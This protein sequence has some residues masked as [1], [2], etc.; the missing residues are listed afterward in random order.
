MTQ[1]QPQKRLLKERVVKIWNLF[2]L[3][4]NDIQEKIKEF[5]K[6]PID[7]IKSILGEFKKEI[8]F[9]ILSLIVIFVLHKPFFKFI[10]KTLVHNIFGYF[11]SNLFYFNTASRIVLCGVLVVLVIFGLIFC[12]K[13][14]KIA[15]R[16]AN[17]DIFWIVYFTI[18]WSILRFYCPHLEDIP[19]RLS[20][21]TRGGTLCYIDLWCLVPFGGFII[22][23]GSYRSRILLRK[24]SSVLEEKKD[25]TPEGKKGT[26]LEEKDTTS[27]EINKSLLDDKELD[28]YNELLPSRQ[29]FVDFIL[30]EIDGLG[31][32][33][34]FSFGITSPWGGGKT[35]FLNG[36]K[37]KLGGKKDIIVVD[38]NPWYAR[39]DREVLSHF[40]DAL[41][42]KLAPY[43]GDLGRNIEGY[44]KLLLSMGDSKFKSAIEHCVSFFASS[45][46]VAQQFDKV[47][48][49]LQE[50]GKKV[51]VIMDDLDRL[52]RDELVSCI[53]ILRNTGDFKGLIFVVTYDKE[54]VTSQLTDYF[55][56]KKQDSKEGARFLEKF[57]QMEVMLPTIKVEEIQDWVLLHLGNM[58]RK[59]FE[60]EY[61]VNLDKNKISTIYSIDALIPLKLR[62]SFLQFIP[63]SFNVSYE[64]RHWDPNDSLTERET[65][66]YYNLN[67]PVNLAIEINNIRQWKRIRNQLI[68]NNHI[69]KGDLD[70]RD[71]IFMIVF[72]ERFPYESFKIYD[73]IRDFL[74]NMEE[75][76]DVGRKR[77]GHFKDFPSLISC[78]NKELS[79]VYVDTI[80]KRIFEIGHFDPTYMRF[81]SALFSLN[82]KINSV[83]YLL[84]YSSYYNQTLEAYFL[85][86]EG[87]KEILNDPN[88]LIYMTRS[89]SEIS[90]KKLIA[91]KEIFIDTFSNNSSLER[92][93]DPDYTTGTI[94][95]MIILSCRSL[96]AKK[97]VDRSYWDFHRICNYFIDSKNKDDLYN[98]IFSRSKYKGDFIDEKILIN[99]LIFFIDKGIKDR[100]MEFAVVLFKLLSKVLDDALEKR[101]VLLEPF[102]S[103]T[104]WFY[105]LKED[106]DD[107]KS[108]FKDVFLELCKKK[109]RLNEMLSIDDNLLFQFILEIENS[110]DTQDKSLYY[111]SEYL[112]VFKNYKDEF[113]LKL[114]GDYSEKQREYVR[115]RYLLLTYKAAPSERFMENLEKVYGLKEQFQNY[116]DYVKKTHDLSIDY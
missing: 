109:E 86:E 81:V 100:C 40:L 79:K 33:R 48:R 88:E 3:L 62:Y 97:K 35:S 13:K 34:S 90:T 16:F 18:C 8:F 115:K 58:F 114:I 24:K 106:Q 93:N 74:P 69:L 84:N 21:L 94:R 64:I 76:P 47:E 6:N 66:V 32:K 17:R 2:V 23:G 25:S 36:L 87:F 68:Q 65:G 31:E 91:F 53:K 55:A 46:D 38:Y 70:L 110:V 89:I 72:K 28:S 51:V 52:G 30:H 19:W 39:N 27:D 63:L 4:S 10:N 105:S 61:E 71:M 78:N 82:K 22:A 107:I 92:V 101:K 104:S 57:I 43:H 9:L 67:V 99:F 41:K 12:G 73:E 29:K 77:L 75:Y 102:V 1:T 11:P 111:C 113:A 112:D 49:C 80:N 45:T 60:K 20:T 54:Y 59:Y 50:I 56:V 98:E 5:C 96:I 95:S 83:G 116:K 103:V 44:R 7:R 85:T 15:Y 26:G 42:S 37:E 14:I 108:T